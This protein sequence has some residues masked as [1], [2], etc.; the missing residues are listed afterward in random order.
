MASPEAS[1]K[2]I[3]SDQRK[4]L[5]RKDLWMHDLFKRMDVEKFR[6]WGERWDARAKQELEE[7][8]RRLERERNSPRNY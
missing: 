4:D 5:M 1:V 3:T 6:T 8:N 7:R 2:H